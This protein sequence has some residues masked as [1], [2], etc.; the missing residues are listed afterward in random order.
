MKDNSQPKYFLFIGKIKRA[1]SFKLVKTATKQAFKV[2]T[3]ID[4]TIL[5]SEV[6]SKWSYLAT[7]KLTLTDVCDQ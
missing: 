4:T 1:I 5:L 2:T 3:L 7:L 6:Y